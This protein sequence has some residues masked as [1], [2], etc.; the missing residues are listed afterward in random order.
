MVSKH[1]PINACLLDN[2]KQN[3]QLCRKKTYALKDKFNN[4]YPMKNDQN[5]NMRLYDYKIR[6][7]IANIKDHLDNGISCR[8]DFT[9]EDEKEI[10][11]I[12]LLT[13]L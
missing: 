4:V 11:N 6:N 3:C 5:C 13:I 8:F 10:K 7:E 9:F 1:C 2:D 12:F